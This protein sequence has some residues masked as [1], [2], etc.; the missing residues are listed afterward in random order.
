M[1][2]VAAPAAHDGEP[3][4]LDTRRGMLTLVIFTT[5]LAEPPF[6]KQDGFWP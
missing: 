4:V 3:S 6:D 2:T 5:R 1:S